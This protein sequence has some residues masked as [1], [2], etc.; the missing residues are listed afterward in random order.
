M[1]DEEERM[2][3]L[4]KGSDV[5]EHEFEEEDWKIDGIKEV[6]DL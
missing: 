3:V 1:N 2:E 6:G 5:Q 4:D